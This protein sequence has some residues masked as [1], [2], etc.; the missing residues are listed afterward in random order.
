MLAYLLDF[1]RQL[2]GRY[3]RMLIAR[4]ADIVSLCICKLASNL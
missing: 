2:V 4:T 3:L 1:E